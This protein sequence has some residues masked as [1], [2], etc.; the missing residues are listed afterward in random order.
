[1]LE[2]FILGA[3]RMAFSLT[4]LSLLAISSSASTFRPRGLRLD[5]LTVLSDLSS[6][7]R[8]SS[9]SS[10]FARLFSAS[11]FGLLIS[12]GLSSSKS[13]KEEECLEE[14]SA[15]CFGF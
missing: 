13:N 8:L 9:S 6:S 7:S 3:A 15:S 4:R 10:G 14:S 12:S 5:L 1:M 11:G 2:S